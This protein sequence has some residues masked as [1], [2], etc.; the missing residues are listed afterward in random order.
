[1]VR[2]RGRPSSWLYALVA[3]PP[4]LGIALFAYNLW[5][6]ISSIS[7]ELTQVEVPGRATLGLAE[8]GTY[9]VF[10]EYQSTVGERVYA[11]PRN[12]PA[13]A[14]ATPLAAGP[15]TRCWSSRSSSRAP[16]S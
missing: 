3:V 10:Y 9:T 12:L 14:P 1:V 5:T 13:A 6:G 2:W 4:L 16:T 15:A 8:P 11:T 7:G